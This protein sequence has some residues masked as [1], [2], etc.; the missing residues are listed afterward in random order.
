MASRAMFV[1]MEIFRRSRILSIS[2]IFSRLSRVSSSSARMRQTSPL[3]LY[4]PD[5]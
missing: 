3:F 4:S 1:S 5:N 2:H